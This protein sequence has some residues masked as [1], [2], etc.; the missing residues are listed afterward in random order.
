M[1]D[2]ITMVN[3]IAVEIRRSNMIP[4]IKNAIN[5]AI[6]E[7]AKYRLYLNEMR[8][9][10]FDT[11]PGQEYYPDM[12]LVE[13]DSFYYYYP[14]STTRFSLYPHSQFAAN[15]DGNLTIGG[16]ITDYARYGEELRLYPVPNTVRAVYLDGFGKLTPWPLVNDTDTNAWMTTGERL[17][18][19]SAKAI[20]LKD[21]IRDYGEA[22]ALESIAADF[23]RSLEHE[24]TM[25]S[26]SGG[27]VSTQ[28]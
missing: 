15:I 26:S 14:N 9:I 17:I 21:V 27:V 11:V 5:D 7:E 28:W 18:R 13:I 22:T 19:A 12:G 3:R 2:F 24:T 20:L 16:Q 25:R 4:E 8:G 23:R 1:T 10:T 6:A